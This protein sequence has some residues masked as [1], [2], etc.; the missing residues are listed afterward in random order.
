M[1]GCTS[2]ERNTPALL[3]EVDTINEEEP[4]VVILSVH[5]GCQMASIMM[6][7]CY[8]KECC[9]ALRAQLCRE[10]RLKIRK[11]ARSDQEH[12][13]KGV[14]GQTWKKALM[15]FVDDLLR[16]QKKKPKGI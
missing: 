2:R 10:M 14:K 16:Y 7:R 5:F 15:C 11:M 3:R 8:R 6:L 9:C 12:P 13:T 1:A 4:Q